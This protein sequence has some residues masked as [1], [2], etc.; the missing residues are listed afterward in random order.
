MYTFCKNL[1][2]VIV[3]KFRLFWLYLTIDEHEMRSL[4]TMGDSTWTTRQKALKPNNFSMFRIINDLLGVD[5]AV[6]SALREH[7]EIC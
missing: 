4:W 1:V 2:L 6:S 7:R 5:A 3:E